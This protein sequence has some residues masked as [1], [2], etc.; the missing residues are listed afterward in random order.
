MKRLIS[1]IGILWACAA[2][3]P[4][5]DFGDVDFEPQIIV[6]G[7]IEEGG[8][9]TVC[10]SQSMTLEMTMGD[11]PMEDIPIRWAKVTVSDGEQEEVLT[12]RMDDAYTPP[13]VYRGSRIR[14][15]AGKTYHL[16]VEYSGKTATASTGI[17]ASVP[18]ESLRVEPCED[19]DTLYQI[20][21]T[22]HDDPASRDYYKVFTRAMPEETRYYSAFMG[23]VADDVFHDHRA[24]MRAN[25][26][27]RYTQL[28]KYTPYFKESDTVLVKLAH[29]TE[30][31]FHFWNA[32]ENEVMNG[33]N[34]LFPNNTNLPSNISGGKGIWYGYGKNTRHVVI[35]DS[36]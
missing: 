4:R 23:T 1:L 25:R 9:P 24:D 7:W 28:G 27:M 21:I 10:L 22:F 29:L 16:K 8:V 5:F 26:G 14:G 20:R 32:Y 30:E 34:P 31:G 2:C 17:P 18:I 13:F 33:K 35:K 6:E 11:M 3:E 15:E 12:G 19:S 36:I